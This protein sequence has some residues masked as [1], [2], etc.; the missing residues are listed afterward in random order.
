M[1][2]GYSLHNTTY[3]FLVINLELSKIS[4]DTIMESRDVTFFENVFSL[5]N[6]LSKFVCDTTWSNLS[7]SSNANK[8]IVFEPRRS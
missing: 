7:S 1:F 5:K 4:N 6:K 3:R 8:D 2:V